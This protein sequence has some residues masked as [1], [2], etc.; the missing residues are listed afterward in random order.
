LLLNATSVDT[1]RRVIASELAPSYR[2]D[3][4]HQNRRVFPE[5]YDLFELLTHIPKDDIPLSTGATLSARFP[6]ISPYGALSSDDPRRP[7]ERVVDGGYFENDGVT[8]A[9]DLALAIKQLRPELEPVVLH[10]TNDPVQR[11][12]DNFSKGHMPE[13]Q[14]PPVAEPRESLWF[15]SLITVIRLHR[16]SEHAVVMQRRPLKRYVQRRGSSTSNFRCL[17][18]PRKGRRSAW[19]AAIFK[20]FHRGLR[21]R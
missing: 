16:F 4:E 10:V 17:I 9:L 15:E 19:G 14:A 2:F 1:G 20:T 3:G 11:A 21:G 6:I 8:T 7:S 18:R 13:R 5:A 12:G